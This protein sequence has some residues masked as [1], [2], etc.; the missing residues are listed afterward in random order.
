[1]RNGLIVL[2]ALF[3]LSCTDPGPAMR[4]V[5][6]IATFNIAMGLNS[7]D[8]LQV[9]LL[10]GEDKNLRKVAAI[11][12]TIRPDILLLNEFDYQAGIDSAAMFNQNYLAVS[13]F[14]GEPIDFPWTHSGP[15]NT[16][17]PSGLD[18]DGNGAID[19]P[20]DSWGFG[21][22]P[23]QYAMALLSVHP[24]DTGAIRK[25]RLFRWQDMPGARLP[26]DPLTG[27][28]WYP[29]EIAGQLR[30]SSKDHWDIPVSIDGCPKRTAT[31]TSSV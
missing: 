17:E 15:V 27:D 10:S 29:E 31:M 6:R 1:M 8:A 7:A 30:L 9:R 21:F 3:T 4:P 12:Q 16:G 23:G 24:L 14:G 20:A 18:L 5:L 2:I 11:I 25:F 26:L 19:D 13:Q 22:F 28:S